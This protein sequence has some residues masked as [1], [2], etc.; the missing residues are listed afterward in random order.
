M[1]SPPHCGQATTRLVAQDPGGPVGAK[2]VG[3]GPQLLT[4]PA[5]ATALPDA[6]GL[7]LSAPPYTPD[8]VWAALK[9]RE[10]AS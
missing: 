9:R 6:T 4:V 7:W 8:K 2:G 1:E 10:R 5:I 3:A